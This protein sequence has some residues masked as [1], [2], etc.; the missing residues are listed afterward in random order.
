MKKWKKLRKFKKFWRN[1]KTKSTTIMKPLNSTLMYQ[2]LSSQKSISKSWKMLSGNKVLK[3]CL[4]FSMKLYT[5]KIH[6]L[7]ITTNSLTSPLINKSKI[8]KLDWQDFKLSSW[9]NITEKRS[10]NSKKPIILKATIH[11]IHY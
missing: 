8:S 5:M 4:D 11:S 1:I 9:A 2:K 6:Q 7:L 10:D 3:I